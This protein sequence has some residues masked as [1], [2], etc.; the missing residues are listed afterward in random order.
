MGI[1]RRTIVELRRLTKLSKNE[2]LTIY[3]ILLSFIRRK[4]L[5]SNRITSDS[6]SP[7]DPSFVILEKYYIGLKEFF[8]FLEQLQM[9]IEENEHLKISS[10]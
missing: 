1:E 10:M 4:E 8:D 6:N 7:P 9:M 3:Q 5:L 2:S